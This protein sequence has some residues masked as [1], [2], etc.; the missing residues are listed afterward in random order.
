MLADGFDFVHETQQPDANGPDAEHVV[1]NVMDHG[2]TGDESVRTHV[3]PN[4][5]AAEDAE[6]LEAM[7]RHHTE[8]PSVFFMK[9]MKALM[10]AAAEPLYDESKVCTKEFTTL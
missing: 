2:F 9:D 6:F 4:N 10:K 8:D 1:P 7:L 3:L 5:M